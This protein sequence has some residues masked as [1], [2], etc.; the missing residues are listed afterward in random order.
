METVAARIMVKE[1]GVTPLDGAVAAVI[2]TP[3]QGTFHEEF[4][5]NIHFNFRY[6]NNPWSY[7]ACRNQ[8]GK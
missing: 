4:T 3:H 2:S 8:W 5:W 7:Q 6:P 1:A